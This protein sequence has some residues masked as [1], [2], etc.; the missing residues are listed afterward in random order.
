MKLKLLSY[1]LL[2]LIVSGGYSEA[3]CQRPVTDT[4]EL[5][6]PGKSAKENEL[7]FDAVK[8]KIHNDNKKAIQ[9]FEQFIAIAPNSAAAYFE[10]SKLYDDAKKPEKAEES[11]KLA[12]G[13]VKDNKW[14]YEQY[15]SILAKQ[16]KYAEAA[17]I[18][19]EIADKET[20]DANYAAMA[21]DFYE[22]AQK[23]TEAINYI[24]KAIVRSG[25]DEEILMH[26]VQIYLHMNEIDKAAGVIRQLLAQ[27]SHNGKYYKLLGELYDNNKMPEKTMQVYKDAEKMAPGDPSIEIGLS[28]HYLNMH[29][30][31]NFRVYAKKAILNKKLDAETQ[32]ELFYA[33][34]QNMSDSAQNAEGMPL[35]AQL[36]TQ[37]PNDAVLIASY[38]EFLESDHQLD[39][40]IQQ[41]KK[42]L[43]LKPS[44]FAVWSRLLNAN[45]DKNNADSLIKYSE[46]VIRLFPNQ[47]LAHYYNAVGHYNKKEYATAVKALNRAIDMLP[48]S[49][50]KGL[51]GM[52]GFLGEIYNSNKQYDLSDK[53][54]DQALKNQP[55]DAT[56]LNNYSYFLS[57]RGQ[58]LDEAKAMSEKSLRIR[59][60]ETT[61]LDTY[62]WIL[63][64]KGEYAKAR[65]FI[66]KAVN[67]KDKKA[68]ATLYEHLGDVC[69][70]L[71]DKLKAIEYWKMAKDKGGE[72][73]LLNK[74]ISEE[75]LY[76]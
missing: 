32:T 51:G 66:E 58:K 76:E 73:P 1:V 40:A 67:A 11:I 28:E 61:F 22:R 69:F 72:N 33:Y 30:T 23:Y 5:P 47:Y 39:K 49:D 46:K 71:N 27:D 55:E 6:V 56:V 48:E 7:F 34:I 35:L 31:V 9:L 20:S 2:S 74:K 63:Y 42:S 13:L 3:Y 60:N 43:A 18:A 24:D 53:A 45:T 25:N 65:E 64:K 75:K 36:L 37:H 26:K 62:G 15:A 12:L 50:V 54:F 10:L 41:Y 52:Y 19:G 57:E 14:Y 44:N 38:G 59:P 68:D 70:K 21:A 16:G 4:V 8:A 17:K 29:D